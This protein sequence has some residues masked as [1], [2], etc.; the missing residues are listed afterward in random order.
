MFHRA[1]SSAMSSTLFQNKQNK[2]NKPARASLRNLLISSPIRTSLPNSPVTPL[3]PTFGSPGTVPVVILRAKYSFSA[4]ASPE[5]SV[6]QSDYAKLIDRP[7]NGWLMVQCIDRNATGLVPA[8]YMSIAVNDVNNPVSLEWL[9]A[10]STQNE[11]VESAAVAAVLLGPDHDVW[12]RLDLVMSTGKRIFCAKH[13]DDFVDLHF[14]LRDKFGLGGMPS[15]P[16]A[17][18]RPMTSVASADAARTEHLAKC[19]ELDAYFGDLIRRTAVCECSI[20]QDF[21]NDTHCK[22]LV[23]ESGAPVPS[24]LRLNNALHGGSISLRDINETTLTFS[25]TAPLPP[26]IQPQRPSAHG[27]TLSFS[28]TAPLPPV[29]LPR[30]SVSKEGTHYS[31]SNL[32][33]LS[34]LNQLPKLLPKQARPALQLSAKDHRSLPES[35]SSNTLSS[36]L[37]LISTYNQL[38]LDDEQPAGLRSSK[39]KSPHSSSSSCEH[40]AD[41]SKHTHYSLD[42]GLLHKAVEPRTPTFGQLYH[43]DQPYN[44]VIAEPILRADADFDLSPLQPKMHRELLSDATINVLPR[45]PAR[46]SNQ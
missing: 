39:R 19:R 36:F 21:V 34:Y 41:M 15:A 38:S 28:P 5:I 35:T 7:G 29:G 22:R 4:Q 10:V 20:M 14:S 26:V 40:G 45:N 16:T 8:L 18:L 9:N 12:Y 31:S 27:R 24:D 3:T 32:K 46:A 17:P 6:G 33:Y 43:I 23:F 13:F 42:L 25:P 2:Q 44:V 37:S 30:S 11:L 1:D